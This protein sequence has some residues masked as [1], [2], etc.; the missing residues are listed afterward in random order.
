MLSCTPCAPGTVASSP[1]SL[2]CDACAPGSAARAEGL[3]LC[4]RCAEGTFAAESGASA[5]RLCPEGYT[6]AAEGG[7]AE[8]DVAT[9]AVLEDHP[10][11]FYLRFTFGVW[12]EGDAG[13]TAVGGDGVAAALGVDASERD[14]FAHLLR[15]DAARGFNVTLAEATASKIAIPALGVDE[16][17]RRR[18]ATRRSLLRSIVGGRACADDAA[19]VAAAEMRVTVQ[20]TE[21]MAE[22]VVTS[23]QEREEKLADAE[24]RAEAALARLVGDPAAFFAGTANTLGPGVRVAVVGNVTREER[25]PEPPAPFRDL[26]DMLP[27]GP[28]AFFGLCAAVGVAWVGYPRASK[29]LADAY[30][31]YRVR[32]ALRAV[33]LGKAG[34]GELQPEMRQMTTAALAELAK[35][36]AQRA[37]SD[38]ERMWDRRTAPP[39]SVGAAEEE[40][41]RL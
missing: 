20:A 9:R 13:A 35:Y 15:V 10:D 25:I 16:S 18:A 34:Y 21:A 5:C 24:T 39:K 7:S 3:S 32:R 41:A 40:R 17:E 30:A 37:K 28:W 31:A 27:V 14:A 2:R 1:R 26:F 12:F 38:L 33:A 36:K 4:A 22:G 6:T 11:V 23:S 29:R 8:C 19:C